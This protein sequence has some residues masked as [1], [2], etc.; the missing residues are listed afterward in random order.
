VLKKKKVLFVT[1]IVVL[2]IEAHRIYRFPGAVFI[3]GNFEQA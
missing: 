1:R 3:G 2:D